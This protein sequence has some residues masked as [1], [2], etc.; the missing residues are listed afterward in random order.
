MNRGTVILLALAILLAHTFAIHQTPNGEFAETYEIAHVAY[1]LGRNLI[2]DGVAQ[3]NPG[4]SPTESYPSPLWVIASA[5]A[6]RVY[7]SPILVSQVVGLAASLATVFVLAQFS[8]KRTSGLIAPVLLASC[9]SAAAAALSGTEASL[10]MLLV[11][12]AFLAFERGSG[13]VLAIAL[14]L[15]FWTRPEGGFA[16]LFLL[17]CALVWRPEEGSGV[18]WRAFRIPLVL[19]V[20]TTAARRAVTGQWV[21]PFVPPLTDWDPERWGI[22]GEYLLSFAVS[23]G[24]GLLILVLIVSVTA[25]RLSA[26]AARS[27]AL[28]CLWWGLVVVSGGD[29]MPFWNALVP[30]LPLFF[31]SVQECLTTWMDERE[32]L[33][34][35]AWTVLLVSVGAAFLVSK[36]PGDVGP[37]RLEPTLSAWQTP[38]GGLARA[39]PRP[40]G[41]LGLLEEIRAVEHLRSLGVFLRDRV[42]ADAVILTTWPGAIGYLSRK[43]VLDLGGRAWPLPGHARPSSWRGVTRVDLVDALI[44]DVDYIVPFVG[45]LS[46]REP[47]TDFLVSWLARYDTVGPTEE[48]IREVLKALQGYM[49]VCVPVPAESRNPRKPSEH[50]FP[51]LQR[52]K[53]EMIPVLKVDSS[54]GRLRVR[55][56]HRGHQLVVDLCVR[57]RL[58]NGQTAV[59]HPDGALEALPAAERAHEPA[60]HPYRRANDPAGRS[61]D[62]RGARGRDDH[63][64]APQSRHAAGRAPLAGGS[65]GF[66]PPLIRGGDSAQ[67]VLLELAIERALPDLQQPRGGEFVAT[68]QAHGVGQRPTLVG[69]EQRN[70]R[71][72][73][74]AKR[75]DL[76]LQGR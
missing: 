54:D 37:L 52:R 40:L 24:F 4:G 15:L 13:R 72:E 32:S 69:F 44:R 53:T 76:V 59:P 26:M 68:G 51:L 71:V 58:E 36:V 11:T 18:G 33:A 6:A 70:G 46:E 73:P 39:Y 23:S 42:G 64:L 74:V 38:R 21:S 61:R 7:I 14:P 43:E 56:Q 22:G 75:A 2:Y 17:G 34:P 63:G 8:T 55:A 5:V 1:R 16:L 19:A 3:W 27:L 65:P 50:P 12:T 28:V 45:T 57:A 35:V 66:A 62:P 10:A 9:G 49:L 25:G 29:G 30:V 60:T 48:R 20:A 31:L 41:R 47:P 67:P